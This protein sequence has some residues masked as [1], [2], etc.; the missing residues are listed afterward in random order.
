MCVHKII[1]SSYSEK[2]DEDGGS[3]KILINPDDKASN[4]SIGGSGNKEG[5]V[6]SLSDT[7]ATSSTKLDISMTSKS[8]IKSES[9]IRKIET[10]KIVVNF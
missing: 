9:F 4:A 10:E 7:S 5:K 1:C 2:K 3:S 6:K 8:S